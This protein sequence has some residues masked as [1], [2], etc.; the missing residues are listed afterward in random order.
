MRNPDFWIWVNKGPDQLRGNRATDQRLC[1]RYIDSTI[2]L[3]PKPEISSHSV[4]VQP[5]LC[6]TWSETLKTRFLATWLIFFVSAGKYPVKPQKQG[7]SQ[8]NR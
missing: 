1:F 7:R 6:Q 4:A 5:G 2:S 3:L 8:S